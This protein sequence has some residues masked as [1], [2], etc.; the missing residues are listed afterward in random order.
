MTRETCETM[1]AALDE[2]LASLGF[3]VFPFYCDAGFSLRA[4]N[5]ATSADAQ[6]AA[7]KISSVIADLDIY[8]VSPTKTGVSLVNPYTD[9]T[10]FEYDASDVT[11]LGLTARPSADGTKNYLVTPA[12]KQYDGIFMFRRENIATDPNA[13]YTDGVSL[14]N[15]MELGDYIEGVLPYEISSSWPLES[16]KAFAI[17]VRSYTMS[18]LNPPQAYGFD[19]CNSTPLSGVSG[20]RAGDRRRRTGGPRDLRSGDD[21]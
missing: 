6:A 4:G 15:V 2:T 9:E 7:S 11:A 16:Q 19:L 1:L 14:T 8:I 17:V 21:I 10:L 13:G 20:S 12:K 18:S 3:D 5:F